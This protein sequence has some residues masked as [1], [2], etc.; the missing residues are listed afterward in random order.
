[1]TST[2]L[3][4]GA[5]LFPPESPPDFLSLEKALDVMNFSIMVQFLSLCMTGYEWCG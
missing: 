5:A 4:M 1:M 3:G 2:S